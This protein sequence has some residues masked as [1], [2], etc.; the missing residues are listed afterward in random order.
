[1][2][3]LPPFWER[4]RR[5]RLFIS[6]SGGKTS[7]FMADRLLSQYRHLWEEII[8]GFGNTGQEHEKTLEYVDACDRHYGFNV[9]WLEAVVNPRTGK[10]TK[11][12]TVRFE[13]AS[14]KG[15]PFEDMIQKYGLPNTQ[16]FHCTRELKLNPIKSYLNYQGWFAGT[17]DSAVGIRF[18]EIDR[19]SPSSMATGVFY[20]LIDL[21]VTKEDVLAWELKQPVR[22]GIPEHLGNCV[23]CWKKSFRK[24]ATVAREQPRA[25]EFPRRMERLYADKGA[26]AGDRRLF[27][28]RRT[29]DDIFEMAQDPS[30]EPFV[31]G[32]PFADETMDAGMACGDG[33]EIGVDGPDEVPATAA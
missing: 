17:Y 10:P 8:V 9:V 16:F 25:F 2:T 20:P 19:M 26:G 21:R 18:D 32:F 1:M 15:E 22:L 27:R 30:F 31:D 11:H 12:R 7:A 14:R 6:F 3:I 29:T 33:C 5:K 23:W 24:L 13:S 4:P 28:G